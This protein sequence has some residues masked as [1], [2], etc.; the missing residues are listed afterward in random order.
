MD[1]A[2]V[3]IKDGKMTVDGYE[4]EALA[5]DKISDGEYELYSLKQVKHGKLKGCFAVT[6]LKKEK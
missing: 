1:A 5:G 4:F 3:L 6:V 2:I